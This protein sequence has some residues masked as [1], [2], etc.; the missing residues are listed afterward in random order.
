MTDCKTCGKCCRFI[1]ISF[2]G[3]LSDDDKKWYELHGVK[4]VN[5]GG[6]GRLLIPFK[7]KALVQ[8]WRTAGDAGLEDGQW[9][10]SIYPDRPKCCKDLEVGGEACL[11]AQEYF[12]HVRAS[13]E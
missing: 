1:I 4:V 6:L 12:K 3:F 11:K 5:E 9:E 2:N 13:G 8:T 7:C 10:C